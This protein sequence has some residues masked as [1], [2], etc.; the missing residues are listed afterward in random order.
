MGFKERQPIFVGQHPG[1][2]SE[3]PPR[4]GGEEPGLQ[5]QAVPQSG[6]QSEGDD[7]GA[8]LGVDPLQATRSRRPCRAEG[9]GQAPRACQ[10]PPK[11]CPQFMMLVFKIPF[12]LSCIL[13]GE[14]QEINILKNMETKQHKR[15]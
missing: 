4:W 8:R 5:W 6:M 12:K 11:G 9:G 10:S 7:K 14:R 15:Q 2:S 3:G 13:E 1:G